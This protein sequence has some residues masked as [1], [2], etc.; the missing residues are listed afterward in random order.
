MTDAL[1]TNL[2]VQGDPASRI[3]LR[4][5]GS[6][7]FREPSSTAGVAAISMLLLLTGC[8]ALR[9]GSGPDWYDGPPDQR[10]RVEAL[11]RDHVLPIVESV[12]GAV[13]PRPAVRLRIVPGR[14]VPIPGGGEGYG[15]TTETA[16]VLSA[17]GLTRRDVLLEELLHATL[18]Q[19]RGERGHPSEYDEWWINH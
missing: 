12:E 13:P 14:T 9:G 5:S 1:A 4:C 3:L 15:Y 19:W 8:S 7:L 17:Y 10:A 18:W 6:R 16:I 11:L 2:T